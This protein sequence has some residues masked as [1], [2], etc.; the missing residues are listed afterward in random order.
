MAKSNIFLFHIL[1]Y[2]NSYVPADLAQKM[3]S[4]C[5]LHLKSC[6]CFP[7]TL[8]D[9]SQSEYI[10]RL[11]YKEEKL[12]RLMD[13]NLHSIFSMESAPLNVVFAE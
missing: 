2:W 5:L 13:V 8:H 6:I 10:F 11:L 1:P 9:Y 7:Y 12:H 4:R 3:Y